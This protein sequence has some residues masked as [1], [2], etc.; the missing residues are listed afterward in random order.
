MRE[1]RPNA[2]RQAVK[3]GIELAMPRRLFQVA[4]AASTGCVYLTFDD[5][6]H[7]EHTPRVLDAL[8][9]AN[10]RATF[11][12]IGEKAALHP[13]LVSRMA[14]E[15][16]AVGHHSYFH[17]P[18]A[19]TSSRALTA[20]VRHTR[21]L[22]KDILGFEPTLFRPP[23]GKATGSKLVQLWLHGQQVVLWNIDSHDFSCTTHQEILDYFHATPLRAGD[24]VLMH[25][26]RPHAAAALPHLLD[27][28]N[29]R[30]LRFNALTT[31]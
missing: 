23:Y 14:G 17:R 8:K 2:L 28:G 3:R 16:H 10:A 15:G 24:I 22:L 4:G 18:Y 6:P 27:E 1:Q 9:K 26:D 12:V 20:E 30:G 7:P 19:E 29:R 25:D 31:R 5:G 11:F 13:S 21:A